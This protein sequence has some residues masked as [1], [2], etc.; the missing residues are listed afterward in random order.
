[1]KQK[2]IINDTFEKHKKLVLEHLNER[3][4]VPTRVN[5]T[6][7][8]TVNI[9]PKKLGKNLPEQQEIKVEVYAEGKYA[10]ASFDHEFG[11]YDPG[12]GYEITK[13]IVTAK[14]NTYVF[15]EEGNQTNEILFNAGDTIDQNSI[16]S[17]I[18]DEIRTNL[19]SAGSDY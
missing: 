10:D 13:V 14:E 1:M 16:V 17:D 18:D 5:T 15:N 9:N 2:S 4:R 6:F 12:S 19:D 11:T 3:R 8:T 7:D